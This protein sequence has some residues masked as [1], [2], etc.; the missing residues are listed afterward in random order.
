MSL[1]PSARSEH[2]STDGR[3]SAIYL[4]DGL[5]AKLLSVCD[6]TAGMEPP[7]PGS[8]IHHDLDDL[9]SEILASSAGSVDSSGAEEVLRRFAER[10]GLVPCLSG[11]NLNWIHGVETLETPPGDLYK[12][13]LE[14]AFGNTSGGTAFENEDQDTAPQTGVS[15]LRVSP[16]SIPERPRARVSRRGCHAPFYF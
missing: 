14:A 15:F 6:V 2:G 13:L 16:S 11:P 5:A 8:P 4:P 9:W 10:Y 12:D 3:R 7:E 1:L